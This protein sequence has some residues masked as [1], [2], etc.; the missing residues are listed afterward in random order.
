MTRR[1]VEEEARRTEGIKNTERKIVADTLQSILSL[2]K[3]NVEAAEKQ[4]P[5]SSPAPQS[6]TKKDRS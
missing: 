1:F 2:R 5:T 3:R 6:P 4:T